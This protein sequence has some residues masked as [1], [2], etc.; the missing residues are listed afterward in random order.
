MKLRAV[1]VLDK[2]F[3]HQYAFCGGKICIYV[4]FNPKR[5]QF[6]SKLPWKTGH[7]Y[8]LQHQNKEL[9][10]HLS[11]HLKTAFSHH[12][13]FPNNIFL[14]FKC[15]LKVFC[16]YQEKLNHKAEVPLQIR[17]GSMPREYQS[18]RSAHKLKQCDL[19]SPGSASSTLSA[20]RAE[21]QISGLSFARCSEVC[22][23]RILS[24]S[25]LR[26]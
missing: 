13:C 23:L 9:G 4:Y 5:S 25:E 20:G 21:L 7:C 8:K 3:Y 10:G 24:A 12:R 16:Q 14:F 6:F 17:Q 19:T 1:I 18:R 22:T 2:W 15:L 11:I 26:P